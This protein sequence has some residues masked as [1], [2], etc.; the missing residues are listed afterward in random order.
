M[1]STPATPAPRSSPV[2]RFW[3]PPLAGAPHLGSDADPSRF[4]TLLTEVSDSRSSS[5]F[6]VESFVV[7]YGQFARGDGSSGAGAVFDNR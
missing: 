1:I 4:R 2:F 3:Q 6:S 5:A 7:G